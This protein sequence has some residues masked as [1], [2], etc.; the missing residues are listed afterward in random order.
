MP[1]NVPLPPGVFGCPVAEM[2]DSSFLLS[3][4]HSSASRAFFPNDACFLRRCLSGTKAC[5]NSAHRKLRHRSRTFGDLTNES[6][7]CMTAMNLCLSFAFGSILRNSS[8]WRMRIVSVF[9]AMPTD[10]HRRCHLASEPLHARALSGDDVGIK[11]CR[12]GKPRVR[13]YIPPRQQWH[14]VDSITGHS[15]RST[16]SR[17]WSNNQAALPS[18][19]LVPP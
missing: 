2:I 6:A 19:G 14:S 8:E 11:V 10:F 9:V 4:F 1:S 7:H 3:V 17:P 12:D 16:P 15:L 13:R 5:C 18:H